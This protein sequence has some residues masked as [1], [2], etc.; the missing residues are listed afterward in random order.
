[1]TVTEEPDARPG[2]KW[3]GTRPIRP[4]G[5]DKV[6]GKARFGADL[7]LPGML[8]GWV[9]RSPHAHARIRSIDV[10]GAAAM[11]GVRAV[12]TGADFPDLAAQGGSPDNVNLSHNVIARDKVLYEGH[13][14][15]AVAATTRQEA[16]QAVEA[17]VVD[18]EVLD[19][20]LTVDEAMADGAP[21]LH[22]GLITRGM[23]PPPTEP[24]NIASRIVHERGD[25]DRGFADA[26]VVIEREITT[27]PV[28]QGY[29]EPHAVVA[30]ASQSGRADV[31]C[32]SQGHFAMRTM[33][34]TVLGWEPSRLKV[35]PAEIGGG[36]GGKTTIYLEPLAVTLSVKAGRPVK[37]VMSRD[38]VFRASGPTSG[39]KIRV[40]LGAT[41][42]GTL[43]AAEAWLA[44]EAGAFPGSP[45]GAAGMTILAP[46]EI[47]NFSVE[48]FDVVVNK[49]KVAA[50]R[51][52]G[53]PMAA[54]AIETVLDEIA[55]EIG[56]DPIEIRLRNAVTE[57]SHA[58]YGPKFP[59][60]GFVETLEA[61][62]DHEH[63]RAPLGPNQGRGLAS[64]FWFNAGMSSSATVHV[65]E[66]GT[67]TVVTGSP[68]IGGSRASMGLMAAEELGVDVARIQPVVADTETVGFNDVTGGSRV[69]LAT[70]AAVV[71]ACRKI[72]DELRARAATTWGV[73]V[74]Q[75]E[76]VDGQAQH[77]G[78]AE[79]PLPL[80]DLAAKAGR[81]GGPIS[82]SASLTARGVG[83]AFSTQLCDVEVDPET[84]VV[85]ILR[86]TT[87]QDAGTAIHPSYVEGQM[88]GGVVQGI[89]WALNEEYVHGADGVME[90]PSFLDYRM[91]VA[92]DLPMIDTVIVEVP[93]PRHPYGVRGVGEV[94]IVPPLAAVANAVFG[95]TGC[96]LRDLPMSPIRILDALVEQERQR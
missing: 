91:P 27:K 67:L 38:E 10:A 53:A 32:S 50:Y 5:F 89:G 92:S 43:T 11:P 75:V 40:K 57:G 65:N 30:D 44:Y 51:A 36:F 12:V 59:R 52:P 47:P 94:G 73:E 6:T 29:I 58:S 25:L 93:N 13:V 20:V 23:D 66:D 46:Y 68:D 4:D 49:P 9:L 74:D 82:A 56:I 86:Y 24:S 80:A 45:V 2:Y 8:Y 19:H 60:I 33:T 70:G 16:K 95:A 88:Q 48:G 35:T 18:Y 78:S 96:R 61:I 17:I 64:G 21:L 79:P 42:D 76:W 83:A 3:V 22:A 77:T 63:Y 81:T 69:T 85:T 55:A 14:V 41:S 87:A 84:G 15:A 37:L 72:K 90:N 39:T 34:A 62:R 7:K 71:E 1:M 54:F 28:H 31:W 26:D